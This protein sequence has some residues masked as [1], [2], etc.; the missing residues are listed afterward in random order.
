M[1]S[2]LPATATVIG[3]V[4]LAQVPTLAE[5]AGIVLVI[6]GVA[7]HREAAAPADVSRASHHMNGM[8]ARRSGG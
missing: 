6:G 4:V 8:S 2:L 7:L 3:L 1:L 5:V